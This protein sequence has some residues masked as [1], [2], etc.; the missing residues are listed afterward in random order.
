MEAA[1][2]DAEIGFAELGAGAP[3]QQA[4]QAKAV[5]EATLQA[6]DAQVDR[7]RE[8]EQ[9]GYQITLVELAVDSM[10]GALDSAGDSAEEMTTHI[11]D[12]EV[13]TEGLA[14]ATGDV[15]FAAATDEA[16][17][18]ASALGVALDT[19]S[20]LAAMGPQG[21]NLGGNPDPSGKVFSGRGGDPQDFGGGFN[22]VVGYLGTQAPGYMGGGASQSGR[23][24]GGGGGGGSSAD[25]QAQA[26]ERLRG[27]LDPTYA[28]MQKLGE[29]QDTL[30]WALEN[31]KISLPEYQALLAD[32]NN[33]FVTGGQEVAD[34]V[35]EL[36]EFMGTFLT[37]IY[38]GL[39]NGEGAW[40]AFKGA[41]LNA[42]DSIANAALKMAGNAFIQ[43]LFGGGAGN[44]L[45]G[46]GGKIFSFDG[47][48]YTGSGARTGGVDG[49]GGFPAILHPNE[50]VVDH[51]K[52]GG[53]AAVTVNI[54]GNLP[55]GTVRQEGNR[56]DID[57][58]A[59]IS[60]VLGSGGADGA[61]RGRYGIQPRGM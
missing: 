16:L 46:I 4:I 36:G 51:T 59:A 18:L 48:G 37:D 47:G 6:R 15:S 2:A 14:A 30:N 9:M 1:R 11:K 53:G 45:P 55:K 56:I 3:N 42:L 58:S 7:N 21:V 24:G 35:Q 39:R 43:M 25:R 20:R 5:A 60:S 19:A 10:S 32:A 33:E 12:S 40:E 23:G 8:I 29:A 17:A 27:Q 61:M 50:T 31:G 22:D 28:A 34:Y 54:S 52:G 26:F 49:R 41:A 13:T 44:V 57:L 38:Q